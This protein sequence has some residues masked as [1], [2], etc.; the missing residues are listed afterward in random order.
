MPKGKVAIRAKGL[1]KVGRQV[2]LYAGI[3]DPISRSLLELRDRGLSMIV[4]TATGW[5]EFM[6]TEWSDHRK[7]L[8]GSAML[9]LPE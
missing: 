6:S 7:R 9:A 8:E 1:R 3:Q 2:K 5:S 4:G